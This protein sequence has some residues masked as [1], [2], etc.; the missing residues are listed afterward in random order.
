MAINKFDNRKKRGDLT[1]F[2]LLPLRDIV[3]F[4]YMVVPLFAARKM[5]NRKWLLK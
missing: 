5:W 1:R 3:I 2:P 4:P